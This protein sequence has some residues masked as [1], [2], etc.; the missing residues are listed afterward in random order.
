MDKIIH[1]ISGETGY[2]AS[3]KEKLL[4]DTVLK[5]FVLNQLVLTSADGRGVRSE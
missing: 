2:F 5:D 3:E 1:P 4:I